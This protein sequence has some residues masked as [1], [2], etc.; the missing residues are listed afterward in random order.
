MLSVS[1]LS[2]VPLHEYDSR[3]MMLLAII[4]IFDLIFLN[5]ILI[6]AEKGRTEKERIK[7]ISD[8]MQFTSFN[9]DW[10]WAWLNLFTT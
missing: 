6:A 5:E 3:N 7:L 4:A 2:A 1:L 10:G 9:L 8:E